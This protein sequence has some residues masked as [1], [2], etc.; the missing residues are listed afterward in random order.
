MNSEQIAH[1]LLVEWLITT[2]AE[3]SRWKRFL[4]AFQIRILE[5]AIL[6]REFPGVK[7]LQEW[8]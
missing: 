8:V 2:E 6:E 4:E 5:D 3:G 1:H 7:G